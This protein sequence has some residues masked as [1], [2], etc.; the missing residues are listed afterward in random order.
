MDF[1]TL[2][3]GFGVFCATFLVGWWLNIG[4]LAAGVPS[5]PAMETATSA[6]QQTPTSQK[7]AVQTPQSKASQSKDSRPQASRFPAWQGGGLG[8]DKHTRDAVIAWSK[9]Y[10]NPRCNQDV[11]WGYTRAATRYA[12]ALMRTAGCNNFPRCP[13][14][15]S[16]LERVWEANRSALDRPVALAIAEANAAGGLSDAAF[17]G[18]VGRAVRVIAGRDF[19]AGPAPHCTASRTRTWGFRFRRR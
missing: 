7:V 3:L 17:R 10:R 15:L 18:D 13:M 1:R 2:A 14:G 19:H 6:N 8:N 5:R 9:S 16:Q 11:R 12:E 4:G